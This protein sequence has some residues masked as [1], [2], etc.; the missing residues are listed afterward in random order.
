MRCRRSVIQR[1]NVVG[2]VP[3]R[4][5]RRRRAIVF[6]QRRRL[7]RGLTSVAIAK[8]LDISPDMVREH[9][10]ALLRR[11]GAANR[12][13]AVAIALRKHLLNLDNTIP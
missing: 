4:R 9:T 8:D 10:S 6:S 11:L 13:E 1:R 2:P 5:Q 12:T 3:G 7:V